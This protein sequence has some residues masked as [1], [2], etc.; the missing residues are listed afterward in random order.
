MS[1]KQYSQRWYLKPSHNL[2]NEFWQ[3]LK[4]FSINL[5]YIDRRDTKSRQWVTR[6]SVSVSLESQ[7]KNWLEIYAKHFTYSWNVVNS[8]LTGVQ[9]GLKNYPDLLMKTAFF[10]N[11]PAFFI[12]SFNKKTGTYKD[13]DG[14]M[15][16]ETFGT[17]GILW[18]FFPQNFVSWKYQNK[19]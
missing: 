1:K 17:T 13:Q 12:W 4:N 2:W 6:V 9:G 11:C 5:I 14:R 10:D 3:I 8:S 19:K 16:F 18:R 15:I 7:N